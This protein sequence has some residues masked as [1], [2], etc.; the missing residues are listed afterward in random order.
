MTHI[1]D[2]DP[3]PAPHK[4]WRWLAVL[5]FVA[6]LWAVLEFTGLR[7]RL[8]LQ[9]LRDSFQDHLALG[10]LTFTGLFAV[11][12]LMHIPGGVFLTAAVLAFGPVVGGGLTYVVANVA[13]L[14]TFFVIRALGGADALRGIDNKIARRIFA[15]LDAHP[16]RSV[17]VL[18]LIFQTMPTLNYALALSGVHWRH[19]FLGTLLGLPIPIIVMTSLL[20]TLASWFGWS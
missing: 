8:N 17:I 20:G 11:A 9:L 5:A 18:R 3:T 2:I 16:L 4:R 13:C 10:L 6:L 1:P 19:Y 15:R 12:N 14:L 7:A